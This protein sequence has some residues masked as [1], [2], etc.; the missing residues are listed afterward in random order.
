[1]YTEQRLPASLN[2]IDSLD[3]S[4]YW[5]AIKTKI[6]D[7]RNLPTWATNHAMKL[8]IVVSQ[9]EK[10]GKYDAIKGMDLEIRKVND[11]IAKAWKV[12]GYIDKYLPDWMAT[13]NAAGSGAPVVS[14]SNG[15]GQ[16]TAP[17]STATPPTATSKVTVYQEPTLI[18]DVTGW[19]GS[20]FGGSGVQA[21]PQDRNLGI[22]PI[23]A[24]VVG[25][26][27][28]AYVV[29]TG[30]ALWQDYVVKKDLTVEVIKGKLTSGQVK[31]I[32]TG[33]RPAESIFEK[34][35]I[36]VGSNVMTMLLVAGAGYLALQYMAGKKLTS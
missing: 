10:E 7:L 6:N 3:F 16:M 12:K 24:T 27:A 23:I 5:N 22:I 1:M 21:F 9:L 34:I 35:G 20:W 32:L 17:P 15:P 13:A 8:G 26:P 36:G 18:Q 29:T 28:L 19:V 14:T 25:L 2:G 11:D 33:G 30:M 4:R 31:D